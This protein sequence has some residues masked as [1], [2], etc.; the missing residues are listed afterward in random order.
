MTKQHCRCSSATAERH[1]SSSGCTQTYGVISRCLE[2]FLLR[3]TI[4]HLSV[5]PEQ[6]AASGFYVAEGPPVKG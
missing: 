4:K 1:L 6:T 5:N 2:S 3:I